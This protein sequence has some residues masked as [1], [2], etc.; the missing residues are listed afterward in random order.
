MD[1]RYSGSKFILT[2]RASSEVWFQSLQKHADRTGPTNLKQL[3]YGY[4]KPNGLKKEHIYLYEKHNQ[5]V[6]QYFKGR[7]QDF[8]EV[9]WETGDKWEEICSFLGHSIPKTKFPWINKSPN[10]WD[11]LIVY[12]KRTLKKI[13]K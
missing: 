3:A 7:D 1:Q 10:L 5:E 4:E 11:K 8:L 13:L 9:C 2:V 12:P 6:R